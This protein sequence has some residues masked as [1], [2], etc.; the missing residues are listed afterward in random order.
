MQ[1][2]NPGQ[3]RNNNYLFFTSRSNTFSWLFLSPERIN[4]RT[5]RYLELI[6][7]QPQDFRKQLRDI[8]MQLW[9]ISARRESFNSRS[10][11]LTTTSTRLWR[12]SSSGFSENK[13]LGGVLSLAGS[14]NLVSVVLI[15]GFS[16]RNDSNIRVFWPNRPGHNNKWF[17]ILKILFLDWQTREI[18]LR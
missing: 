1:W 4:Q 14:W 7:R 11:E 10:A 17:I 5:R 15:D 3:A 6:R 16:K 18:L 13:G 2:R 12:V 9:N 8:R